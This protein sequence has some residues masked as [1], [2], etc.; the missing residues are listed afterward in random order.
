MCSFANRMTKLCQIA[1]EVEYELTREIARK[2]HYGGHGGSIS[3][4]ELASARRRLILR[5]DP[6][7]VAAFDRIKAYLEE[8]PALCDQIV[9]EDVEPGSTKEE[10]VT[11]F[12]GLPPT[13]EALLCHEIAHYMRDVEGAVS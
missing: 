5:G 4:G 9:R 8:R 13:P 10:V 11:E 2:L 12:A 7:A 1:A 6:W 3:L